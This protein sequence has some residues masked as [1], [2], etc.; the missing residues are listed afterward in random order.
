M[1][2][3]VLKKVYQA[4]F[5][6]LFLQKNP[7][8]YMQL[9]WKDAIQIQTAP[10][11]HFRISIVIVAFRIYSS[12]NS[13]QRNSWSQCLFW[14]IFDDFEGAL[15]IPKWFKLLVAARSPFL[16]SLT[17]WLFANW[18]KSIE[19]KCVQLLKSLQCLSVC[20]ALTSLLN[21]GRSNFK[22]IWEIKVIFTIRGGCLVVQINVD[23]RCDIL[24]FSFPFS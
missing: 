2:L 14:C 13:F 12:F 24:P 1:I 3:S 19:T 20:L 17:N 16:M 7:I 11:M 4:K 22:I 23:L 21:F 9:N 6:D 10:L 18:Q 5:E 8:V 15:S